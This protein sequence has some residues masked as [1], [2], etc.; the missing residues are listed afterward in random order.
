[1]K[2]SRLIAAAALLALAS[3]AA[4]ADRDD[5]GP[6]DTGRDDK[7]W[8][9]EQRKAEKEARKDA[10]EAERES[11]KHYEEMER[12]SA[13]HHEEMTKRGRERY[14]EELREREGD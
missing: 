2:I 7:E 13:K 4:I 9:K 11:R 5:K 6:Y 14:E 10:Q 1:M 3:P 12:E 8:A